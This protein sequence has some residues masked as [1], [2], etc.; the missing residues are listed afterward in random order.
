MLDIRGGRPSSPG[1]PVVAPLRPP[2]RPQDSPRTHGSRH[3]RSPQRRQEHPLQRPDDVESGAERQLPLLHDR[4]QRG[5]GERARQAIDQDH[6]VHPAAE[7]DP[8]RFEARRHCGDR[9]RGKRRPGPRQQ[10]PLP[11]PRGR[12]HPPGGSLLRGS[13]RDPRRREGR[14]GLRHGDDRDRARARRH[15]APGKPPPQGGAGCQGGRQ[16][17]QAQGRR[18]EEVPG[19]SQ[20]GAA[21]PHP[22][23]RRR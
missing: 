12:R 7:G 5:D 15:P 13:R 19:P 4:A 1:P 10:V 11:H 18:D 21:G 3:R 8:G 2:P 16:G 14:S 23:P 9:E 17:C 22:R 6:G 20:P